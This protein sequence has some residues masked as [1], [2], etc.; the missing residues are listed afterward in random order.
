MFGKWLSIVQWI[1][2]CENDMLQDS[3]KIFKNNKTMKMKNLVNGCP[4]FNEFNIVKVT[5]TRQFEKI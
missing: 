1:G 3:L 5:C 4:L 2:Y